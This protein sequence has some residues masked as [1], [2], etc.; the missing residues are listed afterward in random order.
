MVH[1]VK[2]PKDDGRRWYMVKVRY[3][4][5]SVMFEETLKI[6]TGSL[7]TAIKQAI[8]DYP[9]IKVEVVSAEEIV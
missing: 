4:K 2:K 8:V 3:K 7:D 9:D 6:Y 1:R 5:Y